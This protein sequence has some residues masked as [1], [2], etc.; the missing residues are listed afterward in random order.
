M[1][2]TYDDLIKFKMPPAESYR[3]ACILYMNI[4][5]WLSELGYKHI[6]K[7]DDPGKHLPTYVYLDSNTTLMCSLKFGIILCKDDE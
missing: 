5:N 7:W 2:L 6:F 3:D 4:R 1:T